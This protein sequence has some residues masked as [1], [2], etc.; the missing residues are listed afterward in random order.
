MLNLRTIQLVALIWEQSQLYRVIWGYFNFLKVLL[1]AMPRPWVS[2]S[3]QIWITSFKWGTVHSC[4]S[5]GCKNIWGQSSRSQRKLP[6]R[7]TQ[8]WCTQGWLN[9]QI[10]YQPPTLTF[11]ILAVPW[12]KSMFN[13]SFE[14]SESYLLKARSPK[15]WHDF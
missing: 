9:W 4:K 13:T 11:D 7:L 12:P 8:T 10:F 1:K 5:K 6:T 15:P 14:R 2:D 3:K